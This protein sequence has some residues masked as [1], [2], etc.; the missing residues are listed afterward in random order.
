MSSTLNSFLTGFVIISIVYMLASISGLFAE[1][2][3]TIN[4]SINGGM[5]VA[6]GA[7]AFTMYVL[8]HSN[9][10]NGLINF[11]IW[12]IFV[13]LLSSLI[14]GIMI[15]FLLSFATITL[16]S[17]QV[18]TGTAINII[19]PIIT[20][21]AL[22]SLN[23]FSS[24]DMNPYIMTTFSN[25][26]TLEIAIITFVIFSIL[27]FI[28]WLIMKFTSFGLRLKSA[29]E[30]P[31]ALA[32]SGI[33]VVKTKYI[34]I[35]ISSILSALAGFVWIA[36]PGL[37]S[38]FNNNVEGIG[39]LALGILIIGQWRFHWVILSGILF[40]ILYSVVHTYTEQ[41]ANAKYILYAIP[42]IGSIIAL[43]LVSKYSRT[44][45][46]IGIPYINSGR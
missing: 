40:S 24:I 21:I 19:A 13:G 22:W 12:M 11:S 18:I 20:I 28:L 39:F 4:L 17:D 2:S 27:I 10:G 16:R 33:S 26:T 9:F 38:S 35:L 8:T 25:L 44:P 6:A 46:A 3:G 30:N 37:S 32:M 23:S 41:F 15:G 45:K 43:P 1:R 5:I 34:A 7:Y 31:Q 29:G 36:L 42:Y 14:I